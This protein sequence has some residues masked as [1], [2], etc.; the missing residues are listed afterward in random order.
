MVLS[1]VAAADVR[2]ML[3][4]KADDVAERAKDTLDT[5]KP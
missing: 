2:D 1:P 4:S 3:R 5:G